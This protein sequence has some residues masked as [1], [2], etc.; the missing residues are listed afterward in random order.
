MLFLLSI[1]YYLRMPIDVLNSEVGRFMGATYSAPVVITS[2]V[3]AVLASFVTLG[4]A[5]RV[6]LSSG[7]MAYVW[8]G[9]GAIVMGSGV[10]SMHFVGMQAFELP[11]ALG[12]NGSMTLLSWGAAVLSAAVALGMTA[13]ERVRYW[14]WL[15]GALVMGCGISAMHYLGMQAI[16]LTIPIT[17]DF[18]VVAL[19]VL[20]AVLASATALQLFRVMCQLSGKRLFVFQTLSALLMGAAI[21]GMHYTGMAAA[22]F[23]NGTVC[24]TVEALGGD[25]L[26]GI[27]VITTAILLMGALFTLALDAR[28]QST[29]FRL[30]ASLSQANAQLQSAN[31]ALRQRAFADPLTD[32]PNRLLF[33]DRL[34]H[35]LVRLE[36]ANQYRVQERVS[37][38]FVDL[39]GFKPIND[40]FGHAAGDEVLILVAQR[41]QALARECDTVARVGGDE[42][43]LL[44]EGVKDLAACT[45]VAQRVI[46]ALAQ[47]FH[48]ANKERQITASVGIVLYPDHGSKAQLMAHADA[49]M[50]AAKRNGG[51][52]YQ[53]FQPHMGSDAAQLLELQNELRHAIERKQIT[54]HYQPKVDGVSGYIIGAEALLRWS[55]PQ[56]GMISPAVF[57][58]LAERFGFIQTLGNW[59]I[60]EACRQL[61][62]WKQLDIHMRVA[63]NLSV[64]QLRE[65]GLAQRIA[66][67][68]QHHQVQPEQLLCEITES[69]AMEDA[70][71]TQRTLEELR[72]IGVFLSIDDFG[73][74]Y[75]SL[76]YLRQLPAQQ[77]KIDASFVR[78]LATQETARAVVQAVINLAHALD[79]R[80]VAEGVET[81]DQSDILLK[82]GC[83]ELQGFFY[84]RPMS[85][86]RLTAWAQGD[87][88]QGA[89]ALSPAICNVA[90]AV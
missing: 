51:N 20:I 65:S 10:W 42:F 59:V 88:P 5:R 16:E 70:Q 8:W 30:N 6:R 82:M 7:G 45:Q 76:S 66:Q 38:L 33:E 34:S 81:Q 71:A 2:I 24:L 14:Q 25:A 55:H 32:L 17:W 40:S 58:P 79:L 52:D 61:A 62:H 22:N 39:D 28:L 72:S 85:A 12:Y 60:E 44:L 67:A 3:I 63:I 19:S 11:I 68:L 75:S 87:K 64:Y 23:A 73:T 31:E 48:V 36:R 15:L 29:A 27:V 84:A 74:G 54:L 21:C 26:T 50:Y 9:C 4:L 89:A 80:V 41:L 49:A 86:E 83:D 35:A 13:R 77:L 57:I 90:E 56:R 53:V 43:L 1:F 78:E 47:P 46:H 69:I 37:I 18:A